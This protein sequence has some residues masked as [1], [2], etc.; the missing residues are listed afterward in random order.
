MKK[1]LAI[2]GIVVF[3]VA[4]SNV[5]HRTIDPK[6][7]KTAIEKSL[8]LLQ[9]SNHTFIAN[10]GGCHSCHGQGLGSVTFSLANEKGFNVPDSSIN[11]GLT[12]IIDT[13]KLRTAYLAQNEDPA[14]VIVGGGYD[15]W[16][17]DATHTP[18]TKMI[19]LLTKNMLQRQRSDGSWV[20]PNKRPPLEY[21]TFSATAL[22]ARGIQHYLPPIFDKEV[23]QRLNRAR[24]WLMNTTPVTNEEKVF[25]I[26]GLVWTNGDTAFIHQQAKKLAATQKDNGGWSQLESL[27]ADA[28]ATGQC[29]YALYQ[30]GYLTNTSAIYQKAVAFLLQTQSPDGSW[31][32]QTRSFPSVPYVNSGFPHGDNQF[33][34]AAG[35]NWATMALL[36][37]VNK[38]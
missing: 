9:Y 32:V 22:T 26:L 1:W 34:S 37:A 16:A 21:Y 10:S 25:Q 20:S 31:N 24:N 27:P 33:I 2:T 28:Y 15:L 8:P 6:E 13:W 12:S 11:E 3:I 17:L 4:F 23:Q 36:L 35:S 19:E 5:D 38:E 14:A 29:L 18:S 30:S 7:V